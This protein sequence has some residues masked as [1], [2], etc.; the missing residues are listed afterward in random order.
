MLVA[1]STVCVQKK[2]VVPLIV[3]WTAPAG[4]VA[5]PLGL[6]ELTGLRAADARALVLN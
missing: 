5:T 1:L 3:V 2:Y 4:S 6:P